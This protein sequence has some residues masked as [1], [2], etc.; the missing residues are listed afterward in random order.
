MKVKVYNK[1][2]GKAPFKEVTRYEFVQLVTKDLIDF[3]I[4]KVVIEI[5]EDDKNLYEN[6][7]KDNILGS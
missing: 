2:T 7:F 3:G 6:T 5:D 1:R 4:E